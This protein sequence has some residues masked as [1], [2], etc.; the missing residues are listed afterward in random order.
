MNDTAM[1]PDCR[2]GKHFACSGR[3]WN[4]DTDQP[5]PCACHCHED[6]IS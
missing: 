5:A 3:G 2:D 4:K 1:D 6:L